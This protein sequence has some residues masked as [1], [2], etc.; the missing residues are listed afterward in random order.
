MVKWAWLLFLSFQDC[1]QIVDLTLTFGFSFL[2]SKIVVPKVNILI[3][4]RSP[5]FSNYQNSFF[6]LWNRKIFKNTI[7]NYAQSTLSD[8]FFAWSVCSLLP[9]WPFRIVDLGWLPLISVLSLF[10]YIQISKADRRIVIRSESFNV[11]FFLSTLLSIFLSFWSFSPY[12]PFRILPK[13]HQKQVTGI[14]FE[15]PFEVYVVP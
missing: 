11:S 15:A 7:S 9:Y 4:D 6:A 13:K 5:I 1:T 8:V 10:S 14:P 2:I 3:P 12:F